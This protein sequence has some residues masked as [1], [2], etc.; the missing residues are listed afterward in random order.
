M[1]LITE[2]I[3]PVE[4]PVMGK[5]IIFDPIQPPGGLFGTIFL[6]PDGQDFLLPDNGFLILPA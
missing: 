6:L 4:F 3:D 1:R 5:P 2:P